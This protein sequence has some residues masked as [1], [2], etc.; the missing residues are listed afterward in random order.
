[1]WFGIIL[2][3]MANGFLLLPVILSFVGN[4]QTAVNPSK[5]NDE[6]SKDDETSRGD[7]T[8]KDN[9]SSKSENTEGEP[10]IGK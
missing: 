3:G 8:S 10:N 7:E 2:F 1:M 6:T 5:M 4:V 9:E